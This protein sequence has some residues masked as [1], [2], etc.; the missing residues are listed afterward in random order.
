MWLYYEGSA[1]CIC[2]ML[3]SSLCHAKLLQSDL[4]EGWMG[5]LGGLVRGLLM[6]YS[7]HVD[8]T[9]NFGTT[10]SVS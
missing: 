4:L 9:V 3:L 1:V 6:R 2:N 7:L 5:A 8:I 10:G